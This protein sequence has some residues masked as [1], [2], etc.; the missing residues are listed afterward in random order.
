MEKRIL[1]L[2]TDAEAA[3][4]TMIGDAESCSRK[5][6]DLEAAFLEMSK[7][8]K[9]NLHKKCIDPLSDALLAQNFP[10]IIEKVEHYPLASLPGKKERWTNIGPINE[11]ESI[12]RTRIEQIAIREILEYE[13]L[14]SFSQAMQSIQRDLVQAIA[15]FRN[16][17]IEVVQ[18]VDFNL[19]TGL[20]ALSEGEASNET[21][22]ES[23]SSGLHRAAENLVGL[24]KSITETLEN[25]GNEMSSAALALAQALE[26]LKNPETIATVRSGLLKAK[27][28]QR[29]KDLRQKAWNYLRFAIPMLWTWIK[30]KVSWLQKEAEQISTKLGLT[31]TSSVIT[32]QV[33]D[34]LAESES[35]IAKL[36][37]VYQRLFRS[38]AVTDELL[39]VPRMDSFEKLH[40]AYANWQLD[41]YAP[42]VLVGEPGAGRS[43]LL[44]K[45]VNVSRKP[46]IKAI[47]LQPPSRIT[48]EEDLC[49]LIRNGL[50]LP[51]CKDTDELIEAI[52]ALSVNRIVLMEDL[53]QYFLKHIGGFAAI[54]SLTRIISETHKKVFWV[55]SIS[56]YAWDYLNKTVGL[57]DAVGY[58]IEL[59]AFT[60]LEIKEIIMKRHRLSG[61]K[62]DF[63]ASDLD[64][65]NQTYRRALEEE[66]PE[67]LKNTYFSDLNHLADSNLSI[68]FL[69]WMRSALSIEEFTLKVG[70][71]KDIDFSF[72][73][74]LHVSKAITLH[75][76]M[77][78]NGL[79]AQELAKVLGI[80]EEAARESLLLLLDDGILIRHKDAYRINPLLY[81]HS[82][83]MLK[84]RNFIH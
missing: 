46:N 33:S 76:L 69:F 58:V 28:I 5:K 79:N 60:D 62:I 23:V 37:L 35:A 63:M 16:R 64:L 73:N 71:L 9:G 47:S 17:G 6:A 82:I 22:Y 11:N 2:L 77:L 29:S 59:G 49:E 65:K 39:F 57:N 43:S 18:I 78:H 80:R 67:I 54:R 36:P 42:T 45:W 83:R 66:R 26:T 25:A 30:G 61:F 31:K 48:T 38:E 50:E 84:K 14:P 72:M 52:N 34:F 70:S 20:A 10:M 19:Q 24:Q 40:Q 27:A 51:E 75:Q 55:F 44:L 81:R 1:P 13:F 4:Q 56:N 53:E 7:E 41:R 3:I 8:V 68:S 74:E 15:Q 32:S 21:V 12:L